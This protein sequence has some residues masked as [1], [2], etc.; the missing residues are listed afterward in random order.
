M[1]WFTFSILGVVVLEIGMLYIMNA[2]RWEERATRD[3]GSWLLEILAPVIDQTVAKVLEGAPKEITSAI[4]GELLA[5]QGGLAR[6][7]M[8]DSGEP[9]D[10][11]IG[12]S[13]AIL[14]Q[15]GY[16]NVNPL[17]ATKLAS[18]LAGIVDKV[19]ETQEEAHSEPLPVGEAVFRQF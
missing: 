18:I 1:D 5:S 19:S 4:K 17:M 8:H 9:A 7:V 6:A 16:K 10:L 14:E 12:M 2:K 15:M 11:M 13:T 3:Q